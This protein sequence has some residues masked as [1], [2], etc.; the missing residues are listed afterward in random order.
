MPSVINKKHS[1]VTLAATYNKQAY[2]WNLK[3]TLLQNV[4]I[5]KH[6]ISNC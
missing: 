2:N 5:H 3:Y 6:R 4:P 1:Y